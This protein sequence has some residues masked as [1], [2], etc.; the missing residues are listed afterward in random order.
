MKRKIGTLMLVAGAFTCLVG[1]VDADILI[2]ANSD[3][4]S[5]QYISSSTNGSFDL[6]AYSGDTFLSGSVTASFLDNSDPMQ[7]S[8]SSTGYIYNGYSTYEYSYDCG[9]FETCYGIGYDYYYYQDHY[10]YNFDPAEGASVLVGA[11][12]QSADSDYYS[13]SYFDGETSGWSGNTNYSDYY[14][15]TD[16]GYTGSFGVTIPLDA[17]ALAAINSGYSL[18]FTINA[19]G[20][21]LVDSVTLN[22]EVVP[23]PATLSLLGLGITA[24]GFSCRRRRR[25]AVAAEYDGWKRRRNEPSVTRDELL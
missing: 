17:T 7:T 18:A 15:T 3:L 10:T 5:G 21:F 2:A 6:G 9:F 22:A 13:Y 24:V 11:S 14:Y 12:T 16:D 19:T 1:Q 25:S 20:D 4:T 23:E 8:N